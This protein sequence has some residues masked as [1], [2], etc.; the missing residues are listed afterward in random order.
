MFVWTE[1]GVQIV[2]PSNR[3]C[4]GKD[5]KGLIDADGK[6]IGELFIETALSEKGEGWIE[7]NW[8]ERNNSEKFR[9][10]TFV[11]KASYGGETYIVGADLYLGN[12]IVCRN[13]EE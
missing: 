13:L 7:Y 5:M 9:K 3:S 2:C 8:Q 12:Y 6:P 11:K 1:N 4:E 10:C